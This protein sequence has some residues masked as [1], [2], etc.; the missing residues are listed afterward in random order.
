MEVQTSQ[1]P[2]EVYE[3]DELSVAQP[4]NDDLVDHLFVV[5]ENNTHPRRGKL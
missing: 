1:S 5:N 4:P 3:V 2:S